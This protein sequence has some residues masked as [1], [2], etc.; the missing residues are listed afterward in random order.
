MKW[1]LTQTV[2]VPLAATLLISG[3]MSYGVTP[4]ASLA[5][6]AA[7]AVSDK[8]HAETGDPG[9]KLMRLPDGAVTIQAAPNVD[10]RLSMNDLFFP[11]YT[12]VVKIDNTLT[13]GKSIDELNQLLQGPIRT[14]TQLLLLQGDVIGTKTLQRYSSDELKGK[15]RFPNNSIFPH[16]ILDTYQNSNGN[17]RAPINQAK[18]QIHSE[19]FPFSMV[20][21]SD[22]YF[23][24][25]IAFIAATTP[26][27]FHFRGFYDD[28]VACLGDALEYFAQI[29]KLDR[30]DLS[31]EAALNAAK[32]NVT[33]LTGSQFSSLLRCADVLTKYNLLSASKTILGHLEP[34]KNK[35]GVDNNISYALSQSRLAIAQ[36][37]T[38]R[39][40]ANI[41]DVINLCMPVKNSDG[42]PQKAA[43]NEAAAYA[44]SQ[45]NTEI[46]VQALQKLNDEPTKAPAYLGIPRAAEQLR[47]A[48]RLA[49]AYAVSQPQKAIEVLKKPLNEYVEKSTRNDIA[50]FNRI[51]TVCP[52][53]INF[54]LASFSLQL[55]QDNDARKYFEEGAKYWSQD[56][57]DDTVEARDIETVSTLFG[58]NSNQPIDEKSK[59]SLTTAVAKLPG[60]KSEPE[61]PISKDENVKTYKDARRI[62]DL[63]AKSQVQQVTKELE[64]S[65]KSECAKSRHNTLD[66]VRLTNFVRASATLIGKQKATNYFEKLDK[67]FSESEATTEP[68]AFY[69]K[70][71][72]VTH[73]E[74]TLE[75]D[76]WREFDKYLSDIAQS[77]GRGARE[78]DNPAARLRDMLTIS[79]AYA[80]SNDLQ[81]AKKFVSYLHAQYP[82]VA[83]NN[84]ELGAF[85]TI[86]YRLLGEQENAEKGLNKLTDPNNKSNSNPALQA[87]VAATYALSKDGTR[88]LRALQHPSETV[89]DKERWDCYKAL[90]LYTLGDF[91]GAASLF[92]GSQASFGQG[93]FEYRRLRGEVLVK[94]GDIDTGI[95]LIC[96]SGDQGT[97]QLAFQRA[98]EL[99]KSSRQISNETLEKLLDRSNR[100]R[101]GSGLGFGGTETDDEQVHETLTDL[102]K[103]AKEHGCNQSKIKMVQDRLDS[104]YIGIVRANNGANPTVPAATTTDQTKED[105]TAKTSFELA[106]K[107]RK[108]ISEQ[109]YKEG[110]DYMLRALRSPDGDR[111]N[112]Y[113]YHYGN[114]RGDLGYEL[115]VQAGQFELLRSI[116]EQ[117]IQTRTAADEKLQ[118]RAKTFARLEKILLA[119]L[120]IE[121]GKFRE[122]EK[123]SNEVLKAVDSDITWCNTPLS[124]EYSGHELSLRLIHKLTEKKEFAI[125]QELL[126]KFDKILAPRVGVKHP[127]WI[128]NRLTRADLLQA[129]GK[130]NDA[131]ELAKNAFDLDVWLYGVNR[132]VHHSRNIYASILRDEGKNAA[133]DSIENTPLKADRRDVSKIYNRNGFSHNDSQTFATDAEEPLKELLE[134]DIAQNGRCGNET[135]RI[136]DELTRFYKEHQRWVDAENV[137]KRKLA[138]FDDVYGPCVIGKVFCFLELA[139]IYRNKGDKN[140]TAKYA[141]QVLALEQSQPDVFA[142]NDGTIHF[143]QPYTN[144]MRFAQVLLFIGKKDAAIAEAKA[145]KDYLTK[146]VRRMGIDSGN[147]ESGLFDACIDFMNTVGATEDVDILK[148]ARVKLYGTERPRDVRRTST[149]TRPAVAN[150]ETAR[151]TIEQKRQDALDKAKRELDDVA[152]NKDTEPKK[153]FP[154]L[155]QMFNA[156][157]AANVPQNGQEIDMEKSDKY[158]REAVEFYSKHSL[159]LDSDASDPRQLQN[160]WSMTRQVSAKTFSELFDKLCKLDDSKCEGERYSDSHMFEALQGSRRE[161]RQSDVRQFLQRAIDI[162]KT[163]LG[164]TSAKLAPLYIYMSICC[165]HLGDTAA[166]ENF[167]LNA[168]S[169][170]TKPYSQMSE[171]LQMSEFYGRIHKADKQENAWRKALAIAKQENKP[172]DSR[173][174]I[175]LME[176]L[177]RDGHTEGADEI[178]NA[179]LANPDPNS[180]SDLDEFLSKQVDDLEKKHDYQHATMLIKKRLSAPKAAAS[181]RMKSSDWQLLLSQTYLEQGNDKESKAAF[182]SALAS[183]SQQGIPTD[184]VKR[185]RAQLLDRLG[186]HADARKLDEQL[187]KLTGK[188]VLAAPMMV[189]QSIRF[190]HNNTFNSFDSNYPTYPVAMR[191]SDRTTPGK[192]LIICQGSVTRAGNL[193]ISGTIACQQSDSEGMRGN[194]VVP[195]PAGIQIN[196]ARQ[197]PPDA[198]RLASNSPAALL[199]TT[200][201]DYVATAIPS[202]TISQTKNIQK[203]VRIFIDDNGDGKDLVCPYVT[204]RDA[205]YL[206]IWYNGNKTIRVRSFSGIIY[207]PHAKVLMEFNGSFRGVLVASQVILEGNNNIELDRSCMGKE[208][209]K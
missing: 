205:S 89:F 109:Q 137:Q 153:Y 179:V 99:A 192:P 85:E 177:Q 54:K 45:K 104:L 161:I 126:N 116:L 37:D 102:L 121:Q 171:W 1:I 14:S 86:L 110:T 117:A 60:V 66:I 39:A 184:E 36:G 49:D 154:A 23:G 180:L 198:I 136:F 35:F 44:L 13:K 51:Y 138:I 57:G 52:A 3:A 46:A 34:A 38:D 149:P 47:S 174:W 78:L 67:I 97:E 144:R 173:S 88:A 72:K 101:L 190:G 16:Q 20:N 160:L 59:T 164:A 157:A 31:V 111:F 140:S 175:R 168:C 200:G 80:I 158:Y 114:L 27:P 40:T 203:P 103:V 127:F 28:Y 199:N 145:V 91:K 17:N 19:N 29:G 94:V 8:A 30:F 125:A 24:A 147:D 107:G 81:K 53:S 128:D 5:D 118:D 61:P 189:K 182:D 71:E 115:L 75:V 204:N 73:Y 43:L 143:S 134:K 162:R 148:Q 15:S 176:E 62:Y 163:D 165:E 9:V 33:S 167:R 82:T 76:H 7:A 92:T 98:V 150:P 155:I 12:Y 96:E 63:I 166:A 146:A 105:E 202:N 129:Q 11:T 152:A 22:R 10:S 2:S 87:N 119:E 193:S 84:K 130:T 201:G 68:A 194:I 191:L 64:Q 41:K 74:P 26:L 186:K 159:V 90:V 56:I 170:T 209:G 187:P 65:L 207:A 131:E 133:A 178:L 100:M 108:L 206:Q 77:A 120:F 142:S 181:S 188:I 32:Q 21:G 42:N 123:Q 50:I 195:V 183:L 124:Q 6:E 196:D 58:A 185:E 106:Q 18:S 172:F 132:G 139:D 83:E 151:H 122:A 48:A 69:V 169:F 112:N 113:M 156:S 208:L 93:T 4:L 25:N 70:A 141:G 197:P 55:G 135:L 95:Q 79:Y